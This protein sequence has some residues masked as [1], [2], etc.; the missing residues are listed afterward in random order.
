MNLLENIHLAV[1]GLIANKMRALLTM[2]GIIIGIGSVIAITSVGNAMTNS[3]NS[4]MSS[5]GVTNIQVMLNSKDNNSVTFEPGDAFTDEMISRYQKKYS[6]KISGIGLSND[7]GSGEIKNKHKTHKV[8]VTG[9]NDGYEITGNIDLAK[10]RFISEKDDQRAKNVAVIS[11]R[12]VASLFSP[13]QNPLGSSIR[14]EMQKGIE[15]FTVIGVFKE[16]AESNFIQRDNT[17][18]NF[19]IPISTAKRLANADEGYFGFTVAAK[20]GIDY[21]QFAQESQNF[22]NTFYKNNKKL[23][24]YAVS[25]DSMISETQG[26]MSTLSIAIA[27]IAGISLLV[28]GIG[29]M[30]IMLVSVT[31]RTREIGIRKALGAP[32]RAIRSQFIIESIIICVIGGIFGI[33]VGAGLGYVGGLLLKQPAVPTLSAII[34]AVG[35]SM[36]IG[37]FF[38]YYPANKAAKLDPIEALRYE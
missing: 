3:V 33:I 13:N 28:G 11:E 35:F 20:M 18:T 2:L 9:V 38:G 26:V 12:L 7:V 34:I 30:N 10:G 4:A 37:I 25:M 17:R 19:Y 1:T 22:M 24:C 36:V 16:P 27:V 23:E 21:T 8:S 31:E 29:V 14:V 6:E 15:T 32:D 5:F